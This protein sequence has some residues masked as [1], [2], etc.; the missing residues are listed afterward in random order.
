MI[1][2]RKTNDEF[3]TRCNVCNKKDNTA[4][5]IV[6]HCGN[7][8]PVITMCKSCREELIT[9]LSEYNKK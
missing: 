6:F 9:K 3:I 5:D 7:M 2:V 1:E 8:N 4:I